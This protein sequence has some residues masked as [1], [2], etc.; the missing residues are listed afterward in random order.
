VVGVV[1]TFVVVVGIKA[2]D[3]VVGGSVF[4]DTVVVGIEV[5]D[6]VVG[7]SVFD[8]TVVVGIKVEDTVVAGIEVE[9]SVVAGATVVEESGSE[10]TEVTLL[11]GAAPF[12]GKAAPVVAGRAEFF[13]RVV[14][15]FDDPSEEPQAA[16][17]SVDTNKNTAERF[18]IEATFFWMLES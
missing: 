3:T 14:S 6:S 8:D 18:F 16:T 17:T 12:E 15:G 9:G 13:K 10:L 11:R 1:V 4:D 5:E 7:G 2:E